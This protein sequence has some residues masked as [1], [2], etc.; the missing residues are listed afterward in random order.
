MVG[1][2]GDVVGCDDGVAGRQGCKVVVVGLGCEVGL[3]GW[4]GVVGV[5]WAR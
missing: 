2:K 3:I 1:S 4:T 5:R